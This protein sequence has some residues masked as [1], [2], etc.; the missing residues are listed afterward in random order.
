M[1]RLIVLM[2]L[3]GLTGMRE[4]AAREILCADTGLE[5]VMIFDPDGKLVW[6]YD[7]VKCV[8]VSVLA[9]GNILMCHESPKNS[10]VREVR[11]SDKKT[12]WEYN[13]KGEAQ[14]CQ[15][16]A[17]GNTLI[18][19]CTDSE[20]I[21][22]TPEGEIAKRIPVTTS[23]KTRHKIL[24]RVRKGADGLYYVAHHGEGVCRVYDDS[25]VIQREIPHYPNFCYSATPLK[26]GTVLL[27]GKE[28]MKIVDQNNKIIW[29]LRPEEV[30]KWKIASF[31]GA[32][33]LDSGNIVVSNWL[34]HGMEGKGTPIIEVTPDKRVVWSFGDTEQTRQVLGVQVI[35]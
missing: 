25:G 31:C 4:L 13:V 14:S 5:K 27:T 20:L 18:G 2:T 19:K 15:R 29:S 17:N 30:S 8:D 26:D 34:G 12:V 21:E 28:L 11:R 7:S 6:Q 23:V 9:G 32:D 35:D 10:W 16:L 24:R 1:L 33:V 22:V 3:C